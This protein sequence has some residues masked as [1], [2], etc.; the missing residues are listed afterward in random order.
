MLD[1]E[2]GPGKPQVGVG[3]TWSL[4][5][6]PVCVGGWVGGDESGGGN[7]RKS[8]WNWRKKAGVMV[9]SGSSGAVKDVGAL[10][11]TSVLSGNLGRVG[12]ETDGSLRSDL[13]R[14]LGPEDLGFGGM[15]RV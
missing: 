12:S 4:G 15:L 2:A 5:A 6:S 9:E 10:G 13:H 7:K 11:G 1:E 3:M 8:T 14:P